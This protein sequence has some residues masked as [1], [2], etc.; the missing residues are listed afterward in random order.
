MKRI[1]PFLLALFLLTGCGGAAAGDA[2]QQIPQE[3][4]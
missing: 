4:A 2:Y 3:E 1:I